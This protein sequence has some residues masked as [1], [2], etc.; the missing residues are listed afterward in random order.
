[1]AKE[2]PTASC[3]VMDTTSDGKGEPTNLCVFSAPMKAH[4]RI[5]RTAEYAEDPAG[6]LQKALGKETFESRRP[7]VSLP[8]TVDMDAYGTGEHRQHF[9][10]HIASFLG[11][12]HGL[13]FVTGIQAQ[14]AALKTYADRAEK[15]YVAWHTSC[16]LEWAEARSFETLYGLE[17]LLLGSDPET[18]PTVDEI[19][20]VLG[21]SNYSRPAAISLEIPNRVLGC[22][23]YTFGELEKI[24]SAC[25]EA[26]VAL[27]M[28]GAR[29]WEIEPYYQATA[30]KS[31]ADLTALFDSVYVSFYKG[32]G[33]ATGAMLVTDDESL[34]DEA[35]LW[36]HRAGG[37]AFTL[38][39]E[40]IDDE[41]AFNENIGTFSRKRDKMI[42]VVDAVTAA[43]AGYKSTDG[44][45]IVNFEP[46][47]PTCCQILTD[48]DGFTEEQLIDARDRV[49]A[50]TSVRIFDRLRP[51]ETV[52]ADEDIQADGNLSGSVNNKRHFKEWMIMSVTE[53]I[54]TRVF[55]DA[56]IDLTM[57][58][59]SILTPTTC[60]TIACVAF[61]LLA[62]SSVWRNQQT[63]QKPAVE[64]NNFTTSRTRPSVLRR[65]RA[66][67]SLYVEDASSIT[68]QFGHWTTQ[69]PLA[70]IDQLIQ[71]CTHV[72]SSLR[73][74]GHLQL[75][76]AQS[77]RFALLQ[78]L[79]LLSA[80]LYQLQQ[81]AASD[82][83]FLASGSSQ[84]A[85]LGANASGISDLLGLIENQE[86]VER[87]SCGDVL[88][89]L[90]AQRVAL[91]SLVASMAA[92][93][94]TP[95]DESDMNRS[96]NVHRA[97][98]PD[99]LRNAS[100][101]SYAPDYSSST[102]L[103]PAAIESRSWLEP[104]PEYSPPSDPSMAAATEKL[105]SKSRD[106]APP[107][108]HNEKEEEVFDTD[109]L[110]N[111]TTTDNTQLV[112]D[113]LLHGADPNQAI[114][115]LQRTPLHQAA[116][117]NHIPTLALLLHHN[118]SLTTEDA[119]GDTPLHLAAW[120]G[121][122]EALTALL[123][124][125]GGALEKIDWLSGRDGYSP[126]WCA[127]SAYHI[128]AARLLLKHGA[129]VSRRSTSGNGLLPLH[130]AA[131]TGQSAMCELLLERGAQVDGL[132]DEASTAL[133]YASAS[134]SCAVVQV[135]LRGGADVKLK[136]KHGLT[137]A[138][139]ASHKGHTEVLELLLSYGAPVDARAV[140][141]ASP[142]HLAA[143]RGHLAAV[144]VLLEKG[145]N[146]GIV[147][148]AWDGAEG[149]PVE[150][151]RA[152]SHKRVAR[153]IEDW[154]K[155]R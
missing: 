94:P 29:L 67:D 11:K 73:E 119:A 115:E 123:A 137:P 9:E 146:R 95:P 52:D 118:A 81:V 71:T 13:F 103:T 84:A 89:P 47:R 57:D 4:E 79:S 85:F 82:T 140:E 17:R 93:P 130:Q 21:H 42:E 58:Q 135:L 153:L 154:P 68:S 34:I 48:F 43:T 138:H 25:R 86:S 145:A 147:A 121:H 51:K 149:T 18:L 112:S 126:L 120:S 134:G 37:R 31:F 80:T 97:G 27:H 61:S 5:K 155:S 109:A 2:I 108:S 90:R 53:K 141:G 35:K 96:L 101:S 152:K 106:A 77:A 33:G 15:P 30:G 40:V 3:E 113:L 24:S 105:D 45:K 124:H 139:W 60:F 50:K 110:Y 100:V 39:Y 91:Q 116:H 65:R 62:V 20:M 102:G 133:H 38:G 28:D 132:D 114:G 143:N 148:E 41:R 32:V 72:S 22:Q 99:F 150:M 1:M 88:L 83:I 10:Q 66:V 78:E 7:M 76:T 142:L 87:L 125:G 55:V 107:R 14:L 104:P 19:T 69:S 49:E 36:Q 64:N 98:R 111:A 128:D 127:I 23:T 16:H 44:N 75:P 92:L 54:E 63:S 70:I 131:V 6:Y 122:C 129:R 26:G 8:K 151:A 74:S 59:H 136:Q 144:R 56:A 12:Q 46:D 117:L